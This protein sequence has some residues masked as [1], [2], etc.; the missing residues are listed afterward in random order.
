MSALQSTLVL[1]S[2]GTHLQ[3]GGGP[4]MLFIEVKDDFSAI[5]TSAEWDM[6]ALF[7]QSDFSVAPGSGQSSDLSIVL[8]DGTKYSTEDTAIDESP[9]KVERSLQIAMTDVSVINLPAR[10]KG[11]KFF[12]VF[13]VKF[14]G[15]VKIVEFGFGEF[16][17]EFTYSQAWG[18][19]LIYNAGI[20]YQ[21]SGRTTTPTFPVLPANTDAL[22]TTAEANMK[23]LGW[24]LAAADATKGGFGNVVAMPDFTALPGTL[25]YV[26]KSI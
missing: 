26:T 16:K 2:L 4:S 8:M 12:F 18:Q 13:P 10:T 23:Y 9:D 11:K 6:L 22:F 5:A 17:R 20:K 3:R 15:T 25:P 1:P 19:Y 7:Q 21:P 14:L 24:L